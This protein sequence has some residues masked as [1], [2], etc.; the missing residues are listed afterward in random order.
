MD[1]Q[2]IVIEFFR[3]YYAAFFQKIFKRIILKKPTFRCLSI[4]PVF[5]SAPWKDGAEFER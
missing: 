1:F 2:F 5:L 4:F 3:F